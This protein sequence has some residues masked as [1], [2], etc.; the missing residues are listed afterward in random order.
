MVKIF[1]NKTARYGNFKE[2]LNCCGI[3]LSLILVAGSLLAALACGRIPFISDWQCPFL[4]LTGCP[5]FSCGMTRALEALLHGRLFEAFKL[6]PLSWLLAGALFFRL[7]QR[8]SETIFKSYPDFRKPR[9]VWGG[10]AAL[11]LL[12]GLIRI[13]LVM[14]VR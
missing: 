4:T 2:W 7:Y 3:E 9:M 1:E 14:V 6:N 13:I 11:A 8:L 12:Y 5:C 10:A